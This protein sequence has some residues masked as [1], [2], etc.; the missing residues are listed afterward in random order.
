LLPV[1]YSVFGVIDGS[2]ARSEISKEQRRRERTSTVQLLCRFV[3]TPTVSDIVTIY[4]GSRLSGV[5]D[6]ISEN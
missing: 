1:T 3:D 4:V 2:I 6:G 5:I